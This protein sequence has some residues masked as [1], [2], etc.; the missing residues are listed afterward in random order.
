[1]KSPDDWMNR[2]V[3]RHREIGLEFQ[4]QHAVLDVIHEIIAEVKAETREELVTLAVGD[5]PH[6]DDVRNLR[7]EVAMPENSG[8]Q[9][10]CDCQQLLAVIDHLEARVAWLASERDVTPEMLVEAEKRG[11]AKAMADFGITQMARMDDADRMPGKGPQK[12]GL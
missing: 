3:E 9:G 10:I 7:E 12:R 11:Y 8:K 6:A 2:I 1:M 5:C 4:I